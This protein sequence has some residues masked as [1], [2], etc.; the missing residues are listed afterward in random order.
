MFKD[1]IKSAEQ[2]MLTN[3]KTEIDKLDEKKRQLVNYR[4]WCQE[5]L[6]RLMVEMAET[7][8]RAFKAVDLEVTD[9]DPCTNR[10]IDG[11]DFLNN[12]PKMTVRFI[13]KM[14]GRRAPWSTSY[15]TKAESKRRKEKCVKDSDKFIIATSG[16]YHT[17]FNEYM[18]SKADRVVVEVYI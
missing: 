3:F 2:D 10:S 8:P 12:P 5:K 13:C 14:I 18:F 9:F 7:L 16:K 17:H 6:S 11:V 1:K 4:D 15:V